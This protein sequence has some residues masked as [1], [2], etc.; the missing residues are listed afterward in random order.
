MINDQETDLHAGN[1]NEQ[2]YMQTRMRTDKKRW[3]KLSHNV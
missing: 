3:Q 2:P 1:G